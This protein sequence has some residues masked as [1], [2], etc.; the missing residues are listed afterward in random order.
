MRA[1][2]LGKGKDIFRV[3]FKKHF[4][5]TPP[6][7]NLSPDTVGKFWHNHK[8]LIALNETPPSGQGEKHHQYKLF[9]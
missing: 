6:V 2:V 8:I 4:Y 1:P 3:P 7:I 5:M 9:L